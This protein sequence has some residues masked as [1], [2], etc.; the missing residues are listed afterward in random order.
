MGA[1][2]GIT[3]GEATMLKT[4]GDFI[5]TWADRAPGRG[6]A[7]SLLVGGSMWAV[8]AVAVWMVLRQVWSIAG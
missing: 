1:V 7:L 8:I 2:S 6:L 3:S 5:E 4:T